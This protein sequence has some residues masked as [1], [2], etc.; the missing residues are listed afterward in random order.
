MIFQVIAPWNIQFDDKRLGDI[1]SFDGDEAANV[2]C[3]WC[4]SIW[5]GAKTLFGFAVIIPYNTKTCWY[6]NIGPLIISSLIEIVDA[7][8]G[9]NVHFC[10]WYGPYDACCRYF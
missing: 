7:V 1:D 9:Y 10:C 8:I 5:G 6:T 3:N 2:D 4:I